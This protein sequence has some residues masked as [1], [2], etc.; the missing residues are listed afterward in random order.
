[1]ASA[2]VIGEFEET[3]L[4]GN[5]AVREFLNYRGNNKEYLNRAKV[6]A[7][8]MGTYARLRATLANES[9]LRMLQERFI[10]HERSDD[11]PALPSAI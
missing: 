4:I 1:M 8:A 6:G 2:N 3:A 5:K 10:K 11:V 9:Q 7:V